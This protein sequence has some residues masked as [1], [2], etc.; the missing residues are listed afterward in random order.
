MNNSFH[1][2]QSIIADTQNAGILYHHLKN[3]LRPPYDYSDL[4][5][6]QWAQSVSALDKLIHDIV[7][8]GMLEIFR[9]QRQPTPK[10]VTFQISLA[11]HDQMR[12][13]PQE[14]VSL[15]EREIMQKHSTLAFQQPE[16][17]ADALSFIWTEKYKWQVLARRL[18]MDENEA[19]TRMKNISIRRNQ[20]VH[21]GDYSNSLL[22][23]QPITE[24]DTQDVLEFIANLGEAIYNEIK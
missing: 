11:L 23:R 20:I 12:Q 4:L 15:L 2:F 6:W 10:Y 7:R 3:V 22:H 13:T 9:G 17:I 18:H 16:K 14:S 1:V 8:I 19:K 5:R 24:E 21:E